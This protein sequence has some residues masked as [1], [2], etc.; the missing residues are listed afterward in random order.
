MLKGIIAHIE[1]KVE[2]LTTILAVLQASEADLTNILKEDDPVAPVT[3]EIRDRVEQAKTGPDEKTKQGEQKPQPQEKGKRGRKTK[4]TA[5]Q[6]KEKNRIYQR[7]WARKKA[8]EKRAAKAE[9]GKPGRIGRPRKKK[10]QLPMTKE[11]R[12][13]LL[14]STFRKRAALRTGLPDGLEN[15]D[16]LNPSDLGIKTGGSVDDD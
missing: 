13:E 14:K 15:S 1:G 4:L 8:A 7:N 9:V 6:I 5:E 2:R 3:Q 12:K 10:G 11:A 16:K